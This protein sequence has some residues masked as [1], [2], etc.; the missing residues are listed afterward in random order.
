MPANPVNSKLRVDQL[1]VEAIGQWTGTGHIRV[2]QLGSEV[3]GAFKL[4]RVRLNQL[5]AEVLGAQALTANNVRANQM[6]VEILGFPTAGIPLTGSGAIHIDQLGVEILRTAAYPA[7]AGDTLGSE[8]YVG[9]GFEEG[10]IPSKEPSTYHPQ[11]PVSEALT[12]FGSLL[13]TDVEVIANSISGV[14]L[15]GT[16]TIQVT[17]PT[18]FAQNCYYV[19]AEYVPQNGDS[20]PIYIK[21]VCTNQNAQGFTITG[22][23]VVGSTTNTVGTFTYAAVG[24]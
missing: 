14:P 8:Y 23:V 9:P 16:T 7:P 10:I 4:A 21:G 6:G 2:N 12:F 5:A 3:L 13:G 18:P 1:G 22:L 17:F 24:L 20:S 15:N 11:W 19:A